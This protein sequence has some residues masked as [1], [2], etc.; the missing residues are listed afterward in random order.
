[1]AAK[2]GRPR[3]TTGS[4]AR[5]SG[6]TSRNKS[7][8]E[9]TLIEAPDNGSTVRSPNCAVTTPAPSR[10]AE[11][12]AKSTAAVMRYGGPSWGGLARSAQLSPVRAALPIRPGRISTPRGIPPA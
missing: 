1:M 5:T 10:L 3:Q 12:K 9:G 2:I 8:N 7:V 11:A 4:P 6:D